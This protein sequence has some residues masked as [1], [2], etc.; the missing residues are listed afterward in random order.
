MIE[1]EAVEIVIEITAAG[2]GTTTTAAERG[3][4]RAMDMTIHAANAGISL[5][6]QHWFV[7]WVPSISQHFFPS[8]LG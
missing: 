2:V 7:E 4:M 5:L 8:L 3:I 1:T 6:R